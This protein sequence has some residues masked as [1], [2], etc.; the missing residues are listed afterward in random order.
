M[1]ERQRLKAAGFS[2]QEIDEYLGTKTKAPVES[3]PASRAPAIPKMAADV[4][5]APRGMSRAEQAQEA[6]RREVRQ[7]RFRQQV[8]TIPAAIANVSRDIPGA[9]AAQAAVRSAVLGQTYREALQD[10][11]GATEA[12]PAAVQLPT[13][14]AG[15]TL[16]ALAMP[17]QTAARQAMA[18][19]AAAGL[20]E[21]SPDIGVG[22]RVARGAG[23][24]LLGGGLAKAGEVATTVARATRAP[25]RA[26]QMLGQARARDVAAE[27]LYKQFRELGP[28]PETDELKEIM[29]LPVIRRAIA[30]VKSESP[31]LQKLQ[32]TDARIL[33]AVYKRIGKK[34]FAS[35]TGFE[36]GE[37]RTALLDAIDNASGGMYRPAVETFRQ[38]SAELTAI[39]RG[40]RALQRAAS[41]SGGTTQQAAMRESPEALVEWAKTAS[42]AEQRRA[43]GGV[44]GELKQHGVSD[45]LTPFGIRGGFSL[46]PGARRAFRAADIITE[47]EG[48]GNLARRA[49]QVGIPAALTP[50][51]NL[52]PR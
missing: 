33:D 17:G 5:A 22:E 11:R 8:A 3:A 27:P 43:I 29:K 42:P 12:L 7:E 31:T 30:T 10:I 4:T 32:N 9:E 19:G 52:P 6:G 47:L 15:G 50:R 25:S 51:D 13:R 1:D 49:F 20:T 23:Q 2:D 40:S 24:A 37:A 26:S 35:K 16:A 46:L 48:R 44:L 34:A 18:Y 39:Q 21:A 41:P 36:T 45:I 38:G 14:L 28:L